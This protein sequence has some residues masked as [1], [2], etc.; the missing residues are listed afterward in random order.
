MDKETIEYI[1]NVLRRGSVTWS[2]RTE[3]LNRNRR[4]RIIG[5]KK[6]GEEKGLWERQCDGCGEWKLLKDNELEVDHIDEVGPYKGDLHDFAS[7]IYCSQ[8]NL[9]ALCFVCHSKKTSNWNATRRFERKFDRS[10][11]AEDL[12]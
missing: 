1:C 2:G 8:E 12:L 4:L 11:K 10:E 7:R 9:Q 5:K 3:C 6:N